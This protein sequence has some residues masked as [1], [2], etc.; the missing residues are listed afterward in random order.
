M[1]FQPP[2]SGPL[3]LPAVRHS[4]TSCNGHAP[5]RC[6]A[7]GGRRQANSR[8]MAAA[9]VA[10]PPLLRHCMAVWPGTGSQKQ[11]AH[12]SREDPTHRPG[13]KNHASG[14]TPASSGAPTRPPPTQ[15]RQWRHGALQ[16]LPYVS[17]VPL[18]E[19]DAEADRVPLHNELGVLPGL[20]EEDHVRINPQLDFVLVPVLNRR[21][22]AYHTTLVR[23]APSSPLLA[24]TTV[25]RLALL[26]PRSSR[27]GSGVP[28][29]SSSL[30]ATALFSQEA[31]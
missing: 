10:S 7:V 6:A 18:K 25:T 3:P 13:I 23:A 26:L 12:Q 17:P 27:L 15:Q 16:V 5:G 31:R 1:C 20:A 4:P 21:P 19:S 14:P 30:S 24:A 11:H 22:K 8:S 28:S 29:T 2:S 9:C